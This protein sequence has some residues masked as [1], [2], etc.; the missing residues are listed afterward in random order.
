L[1]YEE[2]VKLINEKEMK[3]MG[4]QNEK[5]INN[6]N[7]ELEELSNQLEKTEGYKALLLKKV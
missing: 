5:E 4:S 3:L 1:S 6:L 2:I 7:T